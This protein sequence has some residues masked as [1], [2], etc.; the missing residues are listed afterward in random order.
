MRPLMAAE[1]M[2]RAPMPEMVPES[3]TVPAR[4]AGSA[5]IAMPPHSA[6]ATASVNSVRIV[7]SLK[8]L[9]SGRGCAGG[10]CVS[11][12]LENIGRRLGIGIRLFELHFLP[13]ARALGA[14]LLRERQVD[15][16]DLFVVTEVGHGLDRHAI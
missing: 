8:V 4:G 6:A 5:A 15:A 11:R 16:R 7:V 1:P 14:G 12:K 13:L 9:F 10:V 3:I 2:L